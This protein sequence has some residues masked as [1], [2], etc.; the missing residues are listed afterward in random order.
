MARI[1]LATS[2]FAQ[3][4]RKPLD[5]LEASGHT[6]VFNPYGRR[7]RAGEVA[8][9]LKG[10]D[11]VIAGTEPYDSETL[12][13]ADSL[14]V[15]SRVGIGLDSVDL[16][17]C[18]SRHISVTYT[19]DAPTQGVA[20]LTVSNLI[21][22]IRH[23]HSSD[24]SVRENAWNRLMGSLVRDV[25]IGLIGMGRIGTLVA[26]LLEPFNPNI[27]AC[28]ID[29]VVCERE[30]PGVKWVSLDELLAASDLVSL[31]I[32]M[33]EQNRH[34]MDRAKIARMRTGACLINTARGGVLDT[35]A[36]TDALLQ[37]HLG[38][39]ALDVF[40]QEPY[41][42]PLTKLDNVILT[43][44]IAASAKGSRYLMEL[45]A[46]EDCLR[47]LGDETPQNDALADQKKKA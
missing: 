15:I 46:V 21:N 11:A 22:L 43:A 35:D 41:E 5:L 10:I 29:P 42:G 44:H 27:L 2:P 31:H 17:Y 26:R 33:N 39:A 20:E 34:F 1:L 24:R 18:R 37:R 32:P 8:E 9:H 23:I 14:K 3:T 4:G 6:L 47:V 36:L 28:D 16:D 38:G 7:L 40:E 45:G 13:N 30:L 25:T 12:V 19:P